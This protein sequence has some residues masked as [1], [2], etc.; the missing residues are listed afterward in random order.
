[1]YEEHSKSGISRCSEG[2]IYSHRKHGRLC[3]FCCSTLE[4]NHLS[5]PNNEKLVPPKPVIGWLVCLEGEQIG[6]DF[7]VIMEKNFIGK[8][9]DM[10]IKILG[11]DKIAERNHGIIAYDPLNRKTTLVPASGAMTLNYER[12]LN[13]VQLNG[14]EMITI[15]SSHFKF[16]LFCKEHVVWKET[17]TGWRLD[18]S[19][20]ADY[21]FLSLLNSEEQDKNELDSS[22][23][24]VAEKKEISEVENDSFPEEDGYID[25]IEDGEVSAFPLLVSEE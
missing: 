14:G 24:T 10:H 1:M 13:P 21:D 8:T 11:D 7:R 20:L 3:P 16:I 23:T 22:S 18:Q 19:G 6:R 5:I 15:G 17:D 4:G 9:D 12:I 25:E 2:H